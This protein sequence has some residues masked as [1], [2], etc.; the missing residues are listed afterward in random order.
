MV[1]ELVKSENTYQTAFRSVRELSPTVAWLELVRSSAMDCFEQLGFPAVREEDWKYTNLA[2]LAKEEF[3]PVTNVA[4]GANDL[5]RFAYPETAE[6]HLVVVDGFLR[7]DLSTKTSLGDAV[8]VDLFSAAQDARYNK[9]VRKY[10]AR[11]AGYHNNGL[12]ALNTAFLQSGVFLWI[13][14]NVKLER[15]LQITF[16]ADAENG[17][18]FPRLLVVAEENSSATLIESF[19]SSN[20]GKYFTNATAEIVLKDGAQLEHYR[21][22]RESNNAYHV[23]TT[24]AELGRA[25]R[26][27]TTS[28]NFGAQLSRH[29]VSVVMDHE[30]AET[31]VDGLYM[32]GSDQHTDTHSVID[33]KQPHCTSRQLYK[34]ILDGNGRAVFNGKVFVREGAQKTDAQQTNKNLL[35]SDKARVDTKPQL[36]IYADDVKCA[37]G[38]AIGQIDPEELFYLETRGLGPELGRSLL[39]YGF[40]EEVIGKIKIDSIRAQLDE[41]VLRQLHTSL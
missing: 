20:G 25:S 4:R 38:A 31:A 10:L 21:V 8:A 28:I 29:D 41:I 6:A 1:T 35:L 16:V 3:V 22:Q 37:H 26:Y 7:E 18:S 34:G 12:T 39:T 17:A 23:S 15:P 14:K 9:I 19:V 27:D 11:N 5:N 13:P 2:T 24:S 32:A 40:A 33:H 30:G 36:E